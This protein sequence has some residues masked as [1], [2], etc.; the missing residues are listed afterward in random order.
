MWVPFCSGTGACAVLSPT[1]FN[2]FT[3]DFPTLTDIQLALFADDSDMI[4]VVVH[5]KLS[6]GYARLIVFAKFKDLIQTALFMRLQ[7]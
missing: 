1:L 4:S 2:I 6:S 5:K 3:S 7:K